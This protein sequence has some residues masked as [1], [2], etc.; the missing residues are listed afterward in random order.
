[1]SAPSP[2]KS[3]VKYPAGAKAP[4]KAGLKLAP[5]K[6]TM[7]GAKGPK[8]PK[9]AFAKVKPAFFFSLFP[10]FFFF[11]LSFLPYFVGTRRNFEAGACQVQ[12]QCGGLQES[13]TSAERRPSGRLEAVESVAW[14]NGPGSSQEPSGVLVVSRSAE[15]AL[16]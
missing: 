9:G 6:K 1:M 15:E 8:G 10:F 4:K 13:Q 5:P 7:G 16:A 12:G 11:Y 14:L 3:P 2:V